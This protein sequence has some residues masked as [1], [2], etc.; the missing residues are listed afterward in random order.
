M[1][2]PYAAD[3]AFLAALDT[4][5]F[6]ARLLRVAWLG[7][8][9]FLIEYNGSRALLDP[10]LSD[11][12]T[13]KYEATSKPHVRMTERVVAPGCLKGIRVVTASHVHTDHL[14]GET[15]KPLIAANPGIDVV[16]PEAIRNITCH[17]LGCDE[18]WPI[19]FDHGESK[20]VGEF[21]IS[22]VAAAHNEVEVDEQQRHLFLG[23]VI[24][25]GP[26]T[27]FHSGDTLLHPGLLPSL[28]RHSIDLALLP[29]NGNN[30]ARG[31]AGNLDGREAAQLAKEMGARLA[32]PC[33][34][35]MFTFNTAD[36]ETL[37][38]P[39]CERIGVRFEVMQAGQI[40]EISPEEV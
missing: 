19:G 28:K 14:D 34:Y 12:L 2:K 23:Y 29:I 22:A 26:W 30:P 27:V 18:G 13:K 7:Q 1:I 37:F 9:G 24:K 11:A 17:R 32:V 35:D 25:I 3:D 21:S 4:S 16:I 20:N 36:P 5:P 31:V 6:P 15:L 8:S 40:L 39:E 10:Y 33:H 38:V